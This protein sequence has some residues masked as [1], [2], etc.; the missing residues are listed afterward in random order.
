MSWL[1]EAR[2]RDYDPELWFGKNDAKAKQ[3]CRACPAIRDCFDYATELEP[4]VGIWAGIPAYTIRQARQLGVDL[5][6][7]QHN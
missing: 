1:D 4:D 2:C 6:P 5:D 3:I 7:T